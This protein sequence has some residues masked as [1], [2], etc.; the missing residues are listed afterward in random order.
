MTEGAAFPWMFQDTDDVEWYDRF[1]KYYLVL[2][3]ARN[4]LKAYRMFLEAEKPNRAIEFARRPNVVATRD[5]STA[6]RE[7]DWLERSA[8]F[9]A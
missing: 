8:A 4:I 6:A 2:G 5:W 9:D 7:Y 3:P 1:M